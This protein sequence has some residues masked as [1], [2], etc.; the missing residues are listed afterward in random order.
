MLLWPADRFSPGDGAR[1]E[2]RLGRN[3]AS[4]LAAPKK[5]LDPPETSINIG[6]KTIPPPPH[7][8]G[9]GKPDCVYLS[10][11]STSTTSHLNPFTGRR[12]KTRQETP[13]PR[14]KSAPQRGPLFRGTC[15]T[16][17]GLALPLTSPVAWGIVERDSTCRYGER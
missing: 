9:T 12:S 10:H 1:L 8:R 2:R 13:P 6:S 3:P 5:G 14:R 4:L 7:V 16:A 17:V 11:T 15:D